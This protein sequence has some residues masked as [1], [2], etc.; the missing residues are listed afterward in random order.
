MNRIRRHLISVGI[1]VSLALLGTCGMSPAAATESS[2][3]H[4]VTSV[5]HPMPDPHP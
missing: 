4:S 5:P 3:A 1:V 2:G